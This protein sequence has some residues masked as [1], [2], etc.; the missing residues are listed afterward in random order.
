MD[1]NDMV[2]S[3]EKTQ[4]LARGLLELNDNHLEKVKE[5]NNSNLSADTK[6]YLGELIAEQIEG[7]NKIIKSLLGSN[8]DKNSNN[9]NRI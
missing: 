2:I 6:K 7:N 3:K 5:I 4:A 9:Y 8:N 1:N